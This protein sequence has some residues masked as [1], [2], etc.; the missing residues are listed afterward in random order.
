MK[1]SCPTIQELLAFDAVARHQSV[2]RAAE[3]LCVSVSAVSKQVAALEVFVG[4]PLLVKNGRGVQLTAI[5]RSYWESVAR[6]LRVIEKA[7][8][9]IRDAG[10]GSS[11]LV[12]S[13]VPTLLTTWL[14]PRLADFWQRYPGVDFAFRPHLVQNE[15]FPSDIDAAICLGPG[16]WP[17]VRCDYIAGREFVCI[18]ADSL[19]CERRPRESPADLLAYPLLHHDC[20]PSA[21]S[22]WAEC[23]GVDSARAQCGPRFAQYSAVIEAARNGLGIGLV[24]RILV[25]EHLQQGSLTGFFGFRCEDMGHFLCYPHRIEPHPCLSAFRSWLLEQGNDASSPP[26]ARQQDDAEWLAAVV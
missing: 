10:A 22:A 19:W 26:V 2:T 7:T 18:C 6:G 17:E 15:A 8:A 25:G 13:C 4:R 3:V 16:A 11:R 21:W 20:A 1:R 14:I 9:E 24:P 23:Y 12:L 5:G